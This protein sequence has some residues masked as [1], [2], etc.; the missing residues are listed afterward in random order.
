MAASPIVLPRFLALY[1]TLFAAFGVVSPFLGAFLAGRG[2]QPEAIGLVLAAG[3]AVRLFAG[4][5][6]GRLADRLGA[7]RRALTAYAT[8]S[9]VVAFG[10]L[11]AAGLGPLLAVSVGHAVVLAPIVPLADALALAA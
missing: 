4:P 7:P 10:Y 1:T 9:A 2:L 6:G 8:A 3:T 5:L 11:P